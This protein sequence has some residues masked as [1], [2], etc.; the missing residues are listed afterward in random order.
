[1]LFHKKG[2]LRNNLYIQPVVMNCSCRLFC[3]TLNLDCLLV[4]IITIFLIVLLMNLAVA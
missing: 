4:Q 3:V 2:R 1:M